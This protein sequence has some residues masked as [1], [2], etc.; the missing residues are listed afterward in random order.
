[1]EKGRLLIAES[2]APLCG[3]LLDMLRGGFQ[4]QCCADGY[5]ARK[6]LREFRPDVW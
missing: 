3:V 6:C 2:D 4:V 1:M 5:E